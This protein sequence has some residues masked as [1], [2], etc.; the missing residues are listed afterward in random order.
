[1]LSLVLLEFTHCVYI[2]YVIYRMSCTC[3]LLVNTLRT[4]TISSTL[5]LY[6]RWLFSQLCSCQSLQI[7][8]LQP[9]IVVIIKF[10][11]WM[12][13]SHVRKTLWR[14]TIMQ[15]LPKIKGILVLCC[16]SIVN[17]SI[18]QKLKLWYTSVC[19]TKK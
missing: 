1:M 18:R 14:K 7:Q 19:S 3:H 8:S 6:L 11:K 12:L 13:I 4:R 15:L 16:W 9:D 5:C 10:I 17:Q 2:V